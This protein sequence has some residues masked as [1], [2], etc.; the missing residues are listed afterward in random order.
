MVFQRETTK[1]S[2]ERFLMALESMRGSSITLMTTS[3]GISRDTYYRW[4][5]EDAEFRMKVRESWDRFNGFVEDSLKTNIRKNQSWAIKFYLS[6]K[7]PDYM[8][9]GGNK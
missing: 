2:K 3:A 9:R 7:H 4:L 6:R 8:I 1:H 5:K